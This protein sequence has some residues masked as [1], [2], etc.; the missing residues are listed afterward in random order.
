MRWRIL[1]SIFVFVAITLASAES[2]SQVINGLTASCH[3][4]AITVSFSGMS[5]PNLGAPFLFLWREDVSECGPW[6][7][8]GD[9]IFFSPGQSLQFSFDDV[10]AAVDHLYRYKLAFIPPELDVPPA[11]N[12]PFITLYEA[13]AGCG[14]APIGHGLLQTHDYDG[15]P[16]LVP[17]HCTGCFPSL[18]I[19][20]TAVDLTPFADQ[21]WPVALFGSVNFNWQVGWVLQVTSVEPRACVPLAVEASSWSLVKSRYR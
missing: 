10:T 21:A 7:A 2:S 9:P 1:P 18:V 13:Y 8:L 4:T 6:T 3:G 14:T 19:W 20:D 15:F 5:P 17:T 16:V 12:G 11:A